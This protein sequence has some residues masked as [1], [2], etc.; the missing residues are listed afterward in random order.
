M[1]EN[2]N[3]AGDSSCKIGSAVAVQI[4]DCRKQSVPGSK[5]PL[6]LKGSVAVSEQHRTVIGESI[7]RYN[8]RHAVAVNNARLVPDPGFGE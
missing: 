1:A 7:R 8:I 3:V 2:D 6:G 4:G 5:P